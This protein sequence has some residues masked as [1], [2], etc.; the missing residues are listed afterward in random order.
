MSIAKY[1]VKETLRLI[2]DDWLIFRGDMEIGE[3][4][5]VL[6]P[7]PVLITGDEVKF[8]RFKRFFSNDRG[9]SRYFHAH[10]I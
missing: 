2:F 5:T 6:L 1:Y 7:A 9:H 3:R 8:G 4:I 10:E